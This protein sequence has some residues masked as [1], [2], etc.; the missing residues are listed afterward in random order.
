[1]K[2][3]KLRDQN[4]ITL[5]ALVVTIIILLI[6]AGVAISQLG[7]IGLFGKAQQAAE[8]SKIKEYEEKINLVK[9]QAIIEKEG[10]EITLSDLMTIFS[11][12]EESDWVQSV[13]EIEDGGVQKIQLITTDGYMFYV[14]VDDTEYKSANVESP[15]IT[16]EM[17]SFTP[18]DSNWNVDNVKDALD[19]LYNN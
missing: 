2:K 19:Y 9:M 4:A 11:S 1:M 13:E 10:N 18:A 7:E 12:T 14:T 17:L 6:L 16:A 5:V 3:Y 15:T 8:E